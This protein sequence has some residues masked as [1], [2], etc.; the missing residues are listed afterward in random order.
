[1]ECDGVVIVREV[2]DELYDLKTDMLNTAVKGEYVLSSCWES[3]KRDVE[4]T[5]SVSDIHD[6]RVLALVS[7]WLVGPVVIFL[8]AYQKYI[9]EVMPKI[10]YYVKT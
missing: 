2:D 6:E 10:V 7:Q 5:I 3:I 9:Q 1:M 4:G 8:C